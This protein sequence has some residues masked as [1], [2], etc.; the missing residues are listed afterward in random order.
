MSVVERD[1]TVSTMRADPL[2]GIASTKKRTGPCCV[3]SRCAQV[4]RTLEFDSVVVTRNPDASAV[5]ATGV[6]VVDAV[7]VSTV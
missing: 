2:L 7:V 5:V 4:S 3:D 1:F 6:T